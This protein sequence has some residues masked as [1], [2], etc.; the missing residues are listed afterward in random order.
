V[1][2]STRRIFIART[3]AGGCAALALPALVQAAPSHVEESDETAMALGYKHDTKQVDKQRFPKHSPAQ[4]CAN[5]A[6][7]QGSATDEWGGCAMFGRKQVAAT[8][9]CSAWAKK[10]G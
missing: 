10:P 4:N 2:D 9:W 1:K 3:L 7:F 6:F 5:C 8:G